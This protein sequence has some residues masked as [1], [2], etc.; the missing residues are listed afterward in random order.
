MYNQQNINQKSTETPT[1]EDA[2]GIKNPLLTPTTLGQNF[3]SLQSISPLG[4]R[5]IN[6]INWSLISPNQTLLQNFQ[7]N[8][9]WQDSSISEFRPF[10]KNSL[11]EN[12]P[13]IEPQSDK[14]LPS[15][16]PIQLSSELPI[17]QPPETS[18]I[19]SESPIPQPPETPSFDSESPIGQTENIFPFQIDQKTRRNSVIQNSKSSTSHFFQ[20][21]SEFPREKISQENV[22]KLT[23]KSAENQDISTTEE[24]VINS[25]ET[26]DLQT[27]NPTDIPNPEIP[28][29]TLQK[30]SESVS[31]INPTGIVTPEIPVSTLQKQPESV[32]I[33]VSTL[34]KQSDS[35]STIN[36]TDI[37]NPEIPVSTLQKQPESVSVINPTDIVNPEIPVST[38]QKQSESVSTIN[39]TDIVNPE[40]PVSTLQK[41][42]DSASTINPTGIVTP[43]IPVSTLQKQPD[44]AIDNIPQTESVS[45]INPTG[46]VTPEI[47]VSTLQKQSESQTV[48]QL[49]RQPGAI[50]QLP[51]VLE[52][53]THSKPLGIS[54]SLIQP[55]K[56]ISETSF[57]Q[58]NPMLSKD[59]HEN[60]LDNLDQFASPSTINIEP[61]SE[62]NF[63]NESSKQ[64]I[65]IQQ[66][67]SDFSTSDVPD[68]WSSI[69][70]LLGESNS[71]PSKPTVVQAFFKKEGRQAKHRKHQHQ[72]LDFPAGMLLPPGISSGVAGIHNLDLQQQPTSVKV[73]MEKTIQT[74]IQQEQKTAS[75][76][77]EPVETLTRSNL[78]LEYHQSSSASVAQKEETKQAETK[79]DQVEVLAREIY[80]LVRQ[81]FEIERERQGSSY[82][83]R[84]F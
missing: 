67:E 70:E 21:K 4:S 55:S 80:G 76:K 66:Q 24:S 77:A 43:E 14:T 58:T 13:I 52:N 83:R 33:P 26:N 71:T 42:P 34:Q 68:S 56:L 39:P 18:F 75:R 28:V 40:I 36:P 46:I 17:Q 20:K 2:L 65:M 3:L 7:D 84:L 57:L 69:E 27:I 49:L 38:L 48:A 73:L 29:S 44:S 23:K 16:V 50:P 61:K 72:T 10:S 30:Q 53:I 41:Q 25:I 8:E 31:V 35:A 1:E 59:E 5:S 78:G 6:L 62:P 82:D 64:G 74:R 37:I 32:E 79:T 63:N 81:R 54:K 19:D 45:T 47:P 60:V 11:T 51:Q 12:S 15:S 22:N 9:N